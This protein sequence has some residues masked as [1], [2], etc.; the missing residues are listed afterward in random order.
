MRIG[1]QREVAPALQRESSHL[2]REVHASRVAIDLEG[3]VMSG[4]FFE[5]GFEV[6]VRA[7]ARAWPPPGWVTHDVDVRIGDGTQHPLR[8]RSL[9][10]AQLHV[11]RRDDD[12][13]QL[14]HLVGEVER[15]VL[16]DVHLYALEQG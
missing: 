14:E 4:R 1:V 9:L 16:E 3:H 2:R 5:Y 8:H 13:E 12:V 11:R 15:A 6:I 7:L 10:L